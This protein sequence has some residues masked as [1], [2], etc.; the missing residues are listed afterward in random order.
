MSGQAMKIHL[1][2]D[3]L[4]PF[5][6][7][8]HDALAERLRSPAIAGAPRP[9]GPGRQRRCHGRARALRLPGPRVPRRRRGGQAGR[10]QLHRCSFPGA[11]P[12]G[13]GPDIPLADAIFAVQGLG[14]YPIT[15]AGSA[16]QK[17]RYLP[18]VLRGTRITGFGLTEP[19]AGSDVASLQTSAKRRGAN[20]SS[21]AR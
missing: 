8:V 19:E 12:R 16:E 13:P 5:F 15:L 3:D 1:S 14:S 17:Q 7:E 4:R 6:G 2:S 20:G 9:G 10:P 18:G 21:K 11:D